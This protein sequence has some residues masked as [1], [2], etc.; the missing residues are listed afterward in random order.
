MARHR[1]NLP[2]DLSQVITLIRNGRLFALQE[3]IKA[4]NRLH[5]REILDER[6]QSLC[7]AVKTGFHSILEELLKADRWNISEL[8]EALGWALDSRRFDLADLLIAQGAKISELDFE[9]VC[10]TLN[11]SLMER[12]LR[13]GGDPSKGNAFGW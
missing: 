6:A 10:R 12:F 13:E 8:T 3:W 2:E 7:I 4:G 9:A 11:F 5:A 1:P